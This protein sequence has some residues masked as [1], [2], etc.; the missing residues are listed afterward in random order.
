MKRTLALLCAVTVCAALAG[1]GDSS[2]SSS[3]SKETTTTAS[4]TVTEAVTEAVTTTSAPETKAPVTTTE[5]APVE[6]AYTFDPEATESVFEFEEDDIDTAEWANPLGSYFDANTFP[7]DT[8]LKFTIEVKLSDKLLKMMDQGIDPGDKQIGFLPS[9]ANACESFGYDAGWGHFGEKQGTIKADFPLGAELWRMENYTDGKYKLKLYVNADGKNVPDA[10]HEDENLMAVY[11]DVYMADD[12]TKLAPLYC[13]PDG[14][15]KWSPEEWKNWGEEGAVIEFTVTKEV[16]NAC[17]ESIKNAEDPSTAFNGILF[18]SAGGLI[19]K[20]VTI[21]CGNI[22]TN[23]QYL[24]YVA[25]SDGKPWR[26]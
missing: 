20:K 14:M 10:S 21:D 5:A 7:A 8:D 1:C 13:K 15:I 16:V 26:E 24:D 3:D 25:T 4:E 12:D 22:L 23:D 17:I 18:Q 11:E 6:P 9:L 19:F 2:S